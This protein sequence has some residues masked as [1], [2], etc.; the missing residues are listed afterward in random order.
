L[1][2]VFHEIKQGVAADVT[3]AACYKD[4]LHWVV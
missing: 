4:F 3:T 2:A 1:I